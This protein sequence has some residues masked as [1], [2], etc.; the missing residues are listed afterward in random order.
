ML[1]RTLSL[2]R[3][4][5]APGNLVRR[6]SS[7]RKK[8]S[9]GINGY[10]DDTEDD[11]SQYQNPAGRLHMRGGSGGRDD[12]SYFTDSP[13]GRAPA[14]P[15]DQASISVAGRGPNQG[16]VRS[17]FHRTPTGLSAKQIRRTG[18]REINLEGGLDICLN[19]EISQKDPAG[20]TTPYRLLVPA[21]WY[22]EETPGQAA[23]DV[24]LG[25]RR[26]MSLSRKKG[27]TK[28]VSHV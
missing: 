27:N 9:G 21:L 17:Q 10:E 28:E 8:D 7:R 13:T 11:D 6:F 24:Q 1:T 5:F 12:G 3:K 26:W 23:K 16:P 25:L 20:I 4:E 19:V 14:Y 18:V 22:E 15:V 2:T